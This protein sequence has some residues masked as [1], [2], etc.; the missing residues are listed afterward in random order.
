MRDAKFGLGR[1]IELARAK[2]VMFAKHGRTVVV[3]M[4]GRARA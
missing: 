1:L 4:P 3:V 2:P